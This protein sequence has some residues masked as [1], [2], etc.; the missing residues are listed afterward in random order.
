MNKKCK[1][2]SSG[3]IAKPR[4]KVFCQKSCKDA[5]YQLLYQEK[6]KAHKAAIKTNGLLKICEVCSCEFRTN[7]EEA[8][9]CNRAC[10]GKGKS[11]PQRVDREVRRCEVCSEDF[12]V[13]ATQKAR[14]C[15][16]KCVGK[17]KTLKATKIKQC[18][19]CKQDFETKR[20]N[21]FC[22][23]KCSNSGEF[24]NFYGKTGTMTGK[25]SWTTGLTK[26]IDERIA[27]MA[28][29]ISELTKYAF[30]SG[31]R[32]HVG[33]NNPMHGQ[34]HT[35]EAREQ[36]SKT[37]TERIL[38]GDYAT[39]FDK[40]SFES[41][42]NGKSLHYRSSWEHAALKALEQ[43]PSVTSF[44]VEPFSIPYLFEGCVKNYIPDILVHKKDQQALLVEIK[45]KEFLQDPINI[46]KFSAA[47]E[48]CRIH[49]YRFEIWSNDE[50]ARLE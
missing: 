43:D 40:G 34:N 24:H 1:F 9:F 39:W 22:S 16:Q 35:V 17:A 30:A 14:F 49:N 2:C 45:P 47:V 48:Y 6:Y 42:K 11:K 19:N 46:A 26:E 10:A 7:R 12:T 8:R 4:N 15:S 3:F 36:I 32:T 13:R 44:D 18:P 29:T 28:D 25:E 33:E 27:K 37:R 21:K 31:Q 20:G 5:H 38:N 23:Y 41:A 50:I